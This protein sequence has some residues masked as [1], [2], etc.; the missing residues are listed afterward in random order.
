MAALKRMIPRNKGS[1]VLVGSALADRGI[2]LQS[3]YCGSKHG[4]QDFMTA[5][6]QN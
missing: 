2:P 6:A 4:I 3:A 1:I 5:C